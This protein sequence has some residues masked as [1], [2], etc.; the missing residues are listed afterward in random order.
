MRFLLLPFF[1]FLNLALLAQCRTFRI[2]SKGDTL[3]CVDFKGLK[4]G[5][6]FVQIPKLRGEPGY[7][8]EG[9]YKNDRKE[10]TW[11]RYN[12]MG[13][14]LA[15]EN[16]KWGNKHGKSVYFTIDGIEHEENWRALNPDKAYDTIDVADVK[17]PNKFEKV[18]IKTDGSSLKHGIWKYYNPLNG[19]VI[20]TEEYFLDKL[21]T[22]DDAT[23]DTTLAPTIRSLKNNATVKKDSAATKIKPKEVVEFEKK[24][25]GKKKVKVVDGTTKH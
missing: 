1:I 7:E 25:G 8:E 18:I 17:D 24:H 11:R 23:A 21:K 22:P 4:Q 15:M 16:Y 9:E 14:L 12:L 6:W 19:S 2:S 20:N 10:G 3:N 5:K 13:D